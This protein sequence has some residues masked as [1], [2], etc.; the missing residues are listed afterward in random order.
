MIMFTIPGLGYVRLSFW[1][2][3]NVIGACAYHQAKNRIPISQPSDEIK[4]TYIFNL[5]K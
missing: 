4:P 2:G 5:H 1:R 3:Y